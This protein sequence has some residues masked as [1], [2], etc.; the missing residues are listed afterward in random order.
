MEKNFKKNRFCHFREKQ[1]AKLAYTPENCTDETEVTDA[2]PGNE[3]K[4]RICK[5]FQADLESSEARLEAWK[6]EMYQHQKGEY[7]SPNG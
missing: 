4:K 1:D 7:Y 5:Y 3:V 6:M 2:G